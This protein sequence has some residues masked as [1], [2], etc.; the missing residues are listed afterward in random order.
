MWFICSDVNVLYV[1]YFGGEAHGVILIIST[2][3]IIII[4]IHD[5]QPR[6]VIGI[7]IFI[8]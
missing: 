6:Y 2:D 5:H 8:T 3:K 7:F 4:V 1:Q